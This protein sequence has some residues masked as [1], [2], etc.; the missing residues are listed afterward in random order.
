MDITGNDAGMIVASVH[1]FGRLFR[2]ALSDIMDIQGDISR[3]RETI[4]VLIR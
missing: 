3:A 2:S 1:F 4:P